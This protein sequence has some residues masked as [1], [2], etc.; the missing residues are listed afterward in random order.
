MFCDKCG[1]QLPNDACFCSQCGNKIKPVVS[2][3]P[4][5]GAPN[6]AYAGTNP[7]YINKPKTNMV[8]I[9]CILAGLVVVLLVVVGIIGLRSVLKSGGI[10]SAS[11]SGSASASASGKGAEGYYNEKT[12]EFWKSFEETGFPEKLVIEEGITSFDTLPKDDETLQNVKTLVFPSTFEY[13]SGEHF[14]NVEKV[15]INDGPQIIKAQAFQTCKKLKEIELPESITKIGE[16]AFWRCT[17]LTEIVIPEGVTT[18]GDGAFDGC[19]SLKKVHLP[20]SLEYV[21]SGSFEECNKELVISVPSNFDEIV[22]SSQAE[23]KKDSIDPRDPKLQIPDAMLND[24]L[25]VSASFETDGKGKY[26][27][28]TTL[29]AEYP[30]I[31]YYHYR[32]KIKYR[33]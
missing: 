32:G 4:G 9:I 14:P 23:W 17:S 18:I 8:P 12:D 26:S 33:K 5:Y 27:I 22:K 3:N 10:S 16:G 13:P 20:D 11:G 19:T 24:W 2:P 28:R 31:N 6:Y 25:F 21:G 30:D 7:Q 1:C 29:I 15:V